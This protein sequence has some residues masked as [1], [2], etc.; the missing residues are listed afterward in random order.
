MLQRRQTGVNVFEDEIPPDVKAALAHEIK[1][2]LPHS[3]IGKSVFS[4]GGKLVRTVCRNGLKG[5]DI[6]AELCL[7]T[8]RNAHAPPEVQ[9]DTMKGYL[10]R[11]VGRG[12]ACTVPG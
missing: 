10:A 1:A 9:R 2:K 3:M 8:L 12:Q 11:N 5:A 7:T 6:D 4:V